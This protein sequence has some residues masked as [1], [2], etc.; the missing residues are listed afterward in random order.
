MKKLFMHPIYIICTITVFINSTFLLIHKIDRLDN[1]RFISYTPILYM[2]YLII[3]IISA[4][5]IIRQKTSLLPKI[6]LFLCMTL[7][8]ALIMFFAINIATT[9]LHEIFSICIGF[10]FIFCGLVMIYH[11]HQHIYT[12][13][14]I[15]A[16]ESIAS[17]QKLFVIFMSIITMIHLFFGLSHLGKAAYVD[18]KLWI[19]D[20]I[21]KY[22][23]NVIAHDW[24]NTRPSDKPGITTALVSGPGLLF[25]DPTEFR[26][27]SEN[28]DQIEDLFFTFRLPIFLM[29]TILTIYA[30][31]L[32]K[33]LY[34]IKFA[35][36]FYTLISL[37]PL[38]IGISRIINP[39]A[40]LWILFLICFLHYLL[41]IRSR[42]LYHIYATG[43]FLGLS[44]LT[45][46]IANIFIVFFFLL[47]FVHAFL[48]S[49]EKKELSHYFKNTITHF[50]IMLFIALSV[51][52]LLYPG[53][54]VKHDRI[55]LATIFSEAFLSTWKF[56]ACI[57][58]ILLIDVFFFTSRVTIAS[59]S[60]FKH[61]KKLIFYIIISIFTSSIIVMLYNVYTNMSLFDM[62]AIIESPKSIYQDV[63]TSSIYFTSFYPLIFGVTPLVLC[64]FFY[65]LYRA[66]LPSASY[67]DISMIFYSI[68][69]ILIYYCGSVINN[70]VPI[71]R[72]QII[73][74]PLLIL[75]A[76]YGVMYVIE[77]TFHYSDRSFMMI[78]VIIICIGSLELAHLDHY[79][80]SYN[81]PLLP[82]KYIINSKDMGDGNYEIA[83][84]LNALPDAKDLL[85]WTDK[86]GLCQFFIGSC[87]N[88]VQDLA[89]IDI[90]PQIDYYV[91]SQNRQNYIERLTEQ[92]LLHNTKYPVRLDRLFDPHITPVFSILPTGR[93]SQFIHVIKSESVSIID[94]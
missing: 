36:I 56:F 19:Y 61:Y 63:H 86:M 94:K 92:K 30:T 91:I 41:Y 32:V 45:K 67:T 26:E 39:D 72:Y 59:I 82:Q 77:R 46:Y 27:G 79:F 76:T 93:N 65:A 73:I 84:Y 64:G 80:F 2:L 68:L 34:T 47:I 18:E 60:F 5:W 70:V 10:Y 4:V 83:Q 75:I 42:S 88:M 54:W 29:I 48:S 53:A 69:F 58:S 17:N 31:I 3:G 50:I 37:S 16:D 7:P 6:T 23:D 62:M 89:I 21:E 22:W 78:I 15:I 81:S 40:I 28:K 13:R 55:L 38:L 44:L 87:N 8:S 35:L 57:I 51:F 14:K 43:V 20:R 1:L 74:Y 33:K 25:F 9:S 24:I 71:A 66:F 49:L 12:P 52:Y 11:Y 90:A 85:I